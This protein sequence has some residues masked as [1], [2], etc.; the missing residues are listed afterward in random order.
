MYK[1][2]SFRINLLMPKIILKITIVSKIYGFI[3]TLVSLTVQHNGMDVNNYKHE[4]RRY[5]MNINNNSDR[6]TKA[7]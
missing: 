5:K 2:S 4:K 3:T 7:K 6:S 1:T